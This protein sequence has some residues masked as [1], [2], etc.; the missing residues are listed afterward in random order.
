MLVL[1]FQCMN[2][3][4]IGKRRSPYDRMLNLMTC[5][6]NFKSESD[7]FTIHNSIVS[8]YLHANHDVN[9]PFL[10]AAIKTKIALIKFVKYKIISKLKC[11]FPYFQIFTY[12]II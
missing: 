11:A 10:K 6:T 12:R 8:R 3:G 4:H 1:Q 9:Q 7:F 5:I 2:L